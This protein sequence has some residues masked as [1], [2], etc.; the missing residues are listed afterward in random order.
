MNLKH[1]RLLR[2]FVPLGISFL[3]LF[4]L[5]SKIDVD[6]VIESLLKSEKKWIFVAIS[7]SIGINILL[8]AVKWRRILRS[9]GCFFSFREVLSIRTGCIPFKVIFPMKSSE[10]LKA[11]YLKKQNRLGF[12]RSVS[13]MVLDKTLNLFVVIIAVLV[14]L[15]FSDIPV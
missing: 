14:G 3:I 11:A 5:F 9:L 1:T 13:S 6:S 7:I 10:L 8:G 15:G 2:F 4:L 12:T